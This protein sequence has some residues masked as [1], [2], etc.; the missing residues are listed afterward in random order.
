MPALWT[1]R[2]RS[3]ATDSVEVTGPVRLPGPLYYSAFRR[4]LAARAVSAAGS[5]MQTVAAGWLVFD[6]TR[7]ASAV[8]VLTFMSRG[9]GLLLSTYGGELADRY[10]RR[11][12]VIV[13]FV[14]QA[15]AAA[16]LAA[17]AWKDI[18]RVTEVYV[19]TLAIGAT[20]ALANPSLQE[21]V[22]AT[23]P[24]ELARRA[25]GLGSV[26]YNAA[27]LAGPAIGGALVAAIGPGP[28]FA[29]NA[30]SYLAVIVV[31]AT[32]PRSAGASPH[33]RS[34][35]RAAI[36]Q[37]RWDPF[38]RGVILGS[39]MFS[40]LVAPVQEL[41][42]AI[43]RRHGD[44]AHL[45]GFL[46]AALGAGGLIGN[47]VRARLDR[48]GTADTTVMGGC[49]LMCAATLLA[50]AASSDYVLVLGAMT[51]CGAAWDVLYVVS[52]IG[53]QFARPNLSGLMTGLFFAATLGGVTLGALVVG[54]LFDFVGIGPGLAI[55]AGL[56]AAGGV[57]ALGVPSSSSDHQ[58]RSRVRI[59]R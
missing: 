41:A 19:A 16:L 49:M 32:T 11:R 39:V 7:S 23:V 24:P 40:V 35:L 8:G 5:W 13:L 48:R 47:P 20:E 18:S 57:W 50:I 17:V 44:E 33:S 30:V 27:R 15:A 55:C 12:L 1:R 45:L 9:P 36:S 54:A 21:I 3:S 22:T 14:V 6:L 51:V 4:A 2:W 42:P 52:L 29:V 43:A 10:D 38:L 59:R 58:R 46:L 53:V 56:T 37:V 31:I 34:A 28:C 25:A 26:S